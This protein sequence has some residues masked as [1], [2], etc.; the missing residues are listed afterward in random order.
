MLETVNAHLQGRGLSQS[1]GTFLDATI[2]HASSSTKSTDNALD[3]GVHQAKKCGQWYIGMEA[4][5]GMHGLSGMC[6]L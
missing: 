2:M 5:I 3:P 4:H 1:V 6:T